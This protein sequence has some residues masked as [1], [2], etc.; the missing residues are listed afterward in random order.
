MTAVRLIAKRIEK[1]W[2]RR[3]LPLGFGQVSEDRSPVGEIWFDHPDHSHA[4]LLVKFLFTSQKLSI[5][6]HPD[7]EAAQASGGRCGKDEAW[8]ILSAEPNAAIAMGTRQVLSR[9]QLRRAA[10]DGSIDAAMEWTSVAAGDAFYSPAGTVHAIGAGLTLIEVQQNCDTT[11]R[12]FDYGRDRG[13]HLD[14]ALAVA[15][16]ALHPIPARRSSLGSGRVLLVDGP[17]FCLEEW[18]GPLTVTLQ[19]SASRSIWVIPLQP[20]GRLGDEA[21][22]P[23]NVWL[24]EGNTPLHMDEGAALLIAY[25]HDHQ[26]AD[27]NRDVVAQQASF[28]GLIAAD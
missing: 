18:A 26:G 27:L 6:V 19:G 14:R 25:S 1:M 3:D 15:D 28:P 13:L 9:D 17:A 10:L 2:G 7:D 5:Q 4:K 23:G 21:L 20:G 12:L 16:P 11:Y 8:L 24:V 22:E